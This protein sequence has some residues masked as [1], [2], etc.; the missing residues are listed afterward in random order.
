MTRF[1]WSLKQGQCWGLLGSLGFRLFSRALEWRWGPFP[2]LT[3]SRANASDRMGLLELIEWLASWTGHWGRAQG[4]G[5]GPGPG[6][7]DLL[8]M[9]GRADG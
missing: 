3:G 5:P 2:K 6:L 9:N 7:S 4:L 8:F 1:T